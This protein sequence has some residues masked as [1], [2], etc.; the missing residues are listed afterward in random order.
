MLDRKIPGRRRVPS[1]QGLAREEN[2]SLP[3]NSAAGSAHGQQEISEAGPHR[4]ETQGKDELL[5]RLKLT[6]SLKDSFHAR[7]ETPMVNVIM[8][9]PG[10]PFF[11]GLRTPFEDWLETKNNP[12]VQ[13]EALNGD[14]QIILIRPF[15]SQTLS[16]IEQQFLRLLSRDRTLHIV[17]DIPLDPEYRNRDSRIRQYPLVRVRTMADISKLD[18]A[19]GLFAGL[20]LIPFVLEPGAYRC[21]KEGKSVK[22]CLRYRAAYP[23]VPAQ[24]SAVID[25]ERLP[26]QVVPRTVFSG[27]L[28]HRLLLNGALGESGPTVLP[29]EDDVFELQGAD[30]DNRNVLEMTVDE[31]SKALQNGTLTEND[32]LR[33][34]SYTSQVPDPAELLQEAILRETASPEKARAAAEAMRTLNVQTFLQTKGDEI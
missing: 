29:C 34:S 11:Q 23:A 32:V 25:G 27:V 1:V 14:E 5:G 20:E 15:R 12:P 8:N 22:E 3:G 16:P 10:M 21:M 4:A 30:G 19:A 7:K 13:F 28:F 26:E 31:A 33:I 17:S 9:G 2:S 6:E 24:S 18:E